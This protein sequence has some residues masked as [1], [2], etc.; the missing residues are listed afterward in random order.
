M[1]VSCPDPESWELDWDREKSPAGAPPV[2][3][4][5]PSVLL[6]ALWFRGGH[7]YMGG[8]GR[9]LLALRLLGMPLEFGL[10]ALKSSSESF[11][12]VK[13]SIPGIEARKGEVGVGGSSPNIFS[14]VSGSHDGPG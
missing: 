14:Y 4:A 9:G 13:A 2:D 3:L 11:G 1:T 7:W 8:K 5:A 10:E 12:P 6:L